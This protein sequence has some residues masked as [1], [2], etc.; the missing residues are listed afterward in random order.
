M[1]I[2]S[3]LTKEPV[4]SEESV[5]LGVGI[6]YQRNVYEDLFIGGRVGSNGGVGLSLGLGF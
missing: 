5:K 4:D 1:S 6:Q 2:L 3:D